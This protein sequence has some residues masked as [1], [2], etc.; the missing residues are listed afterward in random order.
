MLVCNPGGNIAQVGT[1]LRWTPVKNLTLS[2]EALYSMIDTK[3]VGT[4]A[5]GTIA[6]NNST[7]TFGVRAQRNF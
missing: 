3:Q 6:D 7:W 5:N 1:V 4:Y 2:A